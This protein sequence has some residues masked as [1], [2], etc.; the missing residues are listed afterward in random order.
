MEMS[1]RQQMHR[2][3]MEMVTTSLISIQVRNSKCRHHSLVTVFLT[4]LHNSLGKLHQSTQHF[5]QEQTR[6]S[7]YRSDLTTKFAASG[8]R[9]SHQFEVSHSFKDK[10][11]SLQQ[12]HVVSM[13][14]KQKSGFPETHQQ[15]LSLASQ[16]QTSSNIYVHMHQLRSNGNFEQP[17][18]FKR[19]ATVETRLPSIPPNRKVGQVRT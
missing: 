13:S 9:S 8:S 19:K 3:G 18:A 10:S 11:L 4:S 7:I 12:N 1:V 17:Q 2:L 6:T 16:S 5:S 15:L 14:R